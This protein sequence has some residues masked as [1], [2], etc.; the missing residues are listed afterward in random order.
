MLPHFKCN[1]ISIYFTVYLQLNNF[2]ILSVKSPDSRIHYWIGSQSSQD[3]Q[4]VVAVKAIELDDLLG[5]SPTQFREVQGAESPIFLKYFSPK[6]IR[7]QEGGAASGF[8]HV[9][10]EHRDA[11]YQVKGTKTCRVAEV[12]ISWDSINEGDAYVLDLGAAIF[13][14]RGKSCRHSES[15]TVKF[16]NLSFSLK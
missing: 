2:Q 8:H 12:P 6:G 3:E 9:V 7:V 5:G 4:G 14:W 15:L 1:I 13:V 11:L 10:N 16:E